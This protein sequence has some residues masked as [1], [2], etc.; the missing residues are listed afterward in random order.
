MPTTPDEADTSS[1]TLATGGDDSSVVFG[2]VRL[3]SD[4]AFTVTPGNGAN[5]FSGATAALSSS[6][7]QLGDVTLK[8]VVGATN[9]IAVLDQSLAMVASSRSSLGAIQNRLT[10]T[11]N[12]LNNIAAKTE[13]SLSQIMDADYASETTA[14]SKSQI[15]QQASTAMLA[16]A[17]QANQG[18]LRLLQA[19]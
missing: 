13:Q 4:K 17:N 16:Q 3:S 9:A 12:N 15:L 7:T 18:V 11:V 6:L 10:S 19:G 8:T 2:A 5:L 1:V 14:L